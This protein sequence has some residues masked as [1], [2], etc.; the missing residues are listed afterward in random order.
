MSCLATGMSDPSCD[1][2][3]A[4]RIRMALR[5]PSGYAVLTVEHIGDTLHGE[6]EGDDVP[7]FVPQLS[8]LLGLSYSPPSL[9]GPRALQAAAVRYQGMRLPQAPLLFPRIVQV[10]LQQL[11]SYRDAAAGWRSLLRKHGQ[12]LDDHDGLIVPPGA[13]QLKKLPEHDYVGCN[14]LPQ[15]GRRIAGVARHAKRIESTW[16]SE[17]PDRGERT[18]ALLS[19]L[20]GIGPWTVGF[21]SGSSMGLADAVMPGDYSLP[22]QVAW[23]F[24][25]A[26]EADDELMLRLLEPFQPHRYYAL[27]LVIK[28]GN[29]PPRRGPR[30]RPI[31]RHFRRS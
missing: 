14:I 30:T 13:E 29:G 11:I 19:K 25:R 10:M 18:C 24:Q 31:S 5:S 3:H 27:L 6:L 1:M 26:T 22:A 23:F 21:L 15:H 20:P 16:Q 7:W 17:Q 12:R 28:A 9:Q 8:R 4:D 2:S